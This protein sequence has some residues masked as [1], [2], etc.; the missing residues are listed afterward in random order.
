MQKLYC[1]VDESGQDTKGRI[2]VVSVVVIGHERDDF[3][4]LCQRLEEASGKHKDKWG[5]AK[6]ER[7]MQ[8]LRYIFADH[9]F[10]NSLCYSLFRGDHNFDHA[11]IAAIL[12]AV[13]YKK[14]SGHYT[15]FV[16]VDGLSKTKRHEYGVS[17]RRLG[18]PVRHLG[19]IARDES[20]ALTRLADALA[21]FV[22]DAL[23][24]DSEEIKALFEKAKREEMLVE[25][26]A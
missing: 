17:L 19:G 5:R 26:E 2:F 24:G 23:S 1:Y 11:T 3:L 6:H 25:V 7:R 20:N 13:Q 8:Y 4:Q 9:R 10:R 14:L 16:Y 15:T 21:G 22:R 18:L 12:A